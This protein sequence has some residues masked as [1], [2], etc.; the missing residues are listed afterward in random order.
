[1][2]APAQPLVGNSWVGY[3]SIERV[4]WKMAQWEDHE[5]H[6]GPTCCL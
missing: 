4:H 6:A 2:V 3:L 5:L 1:M